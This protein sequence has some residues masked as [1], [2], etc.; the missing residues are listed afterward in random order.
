MKKLGISLLL[1]VIMVMSISAVNAVDEDV[2]DDLVMSQTDSDVLEIDSVDE[3]VSQAADDVEILSSGTSKNFTQL[4]TDLSSGFLNLGSDY[5]RSEGETEVSISDSVVIIGNG[6][7]K[8]DANNLGGIFNIG[9]AGTLTLNSVILVNGNSDNGGAIYNEGKLNVINSELA[10]NTAS[11]GGA[12][13][14]VGIT[15]V[16]GS[17]FDGNDATNLGGAIYS[18]GVLLV[19][20]SNFNDNT[21]VYRG[22]AI[23]SSED[24]EISGSK[25][26]A[27]DITYRLR[28]EDNGGAA[29]YVNNAN[30]NL[31]NSQIINNGINFKYRTS[32]NEE[33]DLLDG[34]VNLV[35]SSA[36]V[37]GCLFENNA[38][39]YGGALNI[40][41]NDN[42]MDYLTVT[43][44]QFIN[45]KGYNGAGINI[46]NCIFD[47]D[48]CNFVD[49][50]AIGIG[51]PDYVSVGGGVSFDGAQSVGTITDSNFT[52]NSANIGGAIYAGTDDAE[53]TATISGCNFKDNAAL[54]RGGAILDVGFLEVSNSNFSGNDAPIGKAI[55][56]GGILSLSENVVNENAG[57]YIS[58][59]C[60]LNSNV[61]ITI[62]D[63]A[64]YTINAYDPFTVKAEVTDDNGNVIRT[65]NDK[66][67]IWCGP[68]SVSGSQP[69]SLIFNEET[70]LYEAPIEPVKSGQIYMGNTRST[71]PYVDSSLITQNKAYVTVNPID[72]QLE[73]T[74][75][76]ITYPDDLTVSVNISRKGTP[77][78]A[79][80]RITI[81][82]VTKS[83]TTK[84]GV[85]SAIFEGLSAGNYVIT[86]TVAKSTGYNAIEQVYDLVVFDVQG[87]FADLQYKIA[88]SNGI[89]DLPYDFAYIESYDGNNFPDGVVIA[90]D[91]TINGN[92]KTIS[93]NDLNRIFKV[94][95][96]V[97]LTLNNVT[98]C[99]GAAS[100]GAAVYVESGAKLVANDAKFKD[101][102]ADDNGG[103]I[104]L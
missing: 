2:S 56:D 8:I 22:G 15:S 97:T 93:G 27:N 86:A 69:G 38:A 61:I 31:V 34:V 90:S 43:N 94:A 54:E 9:Q 73:V 84:N 30:L 26:D 13:Y 75:E 45:N 76:N 16:S 102:V 70:G 99:D 88:N 100:D 64:T 32:E 4:Q 92:G 36:T 80:V 40:I 78:S 35:D 62:N 74:Y 57:I 79:T 19:D 51:S 82:G 33:R 58:Q 7:Y 10:D 63:N 83:I 18:N 42:T 44:S 25:F 17:T 53:H 23:Y 41:N 59:N 12:I 96:G 72:R 47:I 60:K 46:E 103:A 20:K 67:G 37:S 71:F 11:I 48:D 49:N 81:D 77:L 24:L 95:E 5:V 87:T 28:N 55:Y 29:I 85:G 6:E 101:N 91:L 68:S 104:M 50:Q 66:I 14:N 39:C 65:Y 89:L 52:G 21:A 1:V 3:D 98:I